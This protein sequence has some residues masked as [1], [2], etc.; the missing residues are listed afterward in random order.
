MVSY[1]KTLKTIY[2]HAIPELEN[3]YNECKFDNNS[4]SLNELIIQFH[5]SHL[6]DTGCFNAGKILKVLP[7]Q[8][9]WIVRKFLKHNFKKTPC[10]QWA[11]ACEALKDALIW[12]WANE[13]EVMDHIQE[14]SP[15]RR[16]VC[17]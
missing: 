5:F 1:V 17:V 16:S 6:L 9:H 11:K 7:K 4:L 15:V 10:V 13:E 14:H 3:I 2:S 12:N 8:Y